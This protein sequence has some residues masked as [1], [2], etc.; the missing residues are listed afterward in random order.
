MPT[1]FDGHLLVGDDTAL[2]AIARRLAEL[3][4]GARTLVLVE[5]DGPQDELVFNTAANVKVVWVHRH[6][7]KHGNALL[8]RLPTLPL[9]PGD[10]YAWVAC[11]YSAAKALRSHLV[12]T[13]G[14]Q[15]QWV[16]AASYWRYGSADS[17]E[18]IED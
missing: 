3:P 8:E 5:V 10:I 14:L 17:H 12:D 2:P 7:G 1:D 18:K 6:G 9:P 4:A 15:K 13:R 16:K 11:E